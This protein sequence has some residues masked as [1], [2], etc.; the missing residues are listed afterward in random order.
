MQGIH[1][2]E[3]SRPAALPPRSAQQTLSTALHQL[4]Q[5]QLEWGGLDYL[6]I[7][8][9]FDSISKESHTAAFE[10]K[11]LAHAVKGCDVP[12]IALGGNFYPAQSFTPTTK[13]YWIGLHSLH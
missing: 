3:Y 6:F 4:T 13:V 11:A 5:L 7:S 8:P 1:Y 9:V 12:V 10:P 2:P